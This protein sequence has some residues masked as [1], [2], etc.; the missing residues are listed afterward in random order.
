MYTCGFT[1]SSA[2]LRASVPL[3]ERR[4]LLASFCGVGGMVFG[5]DGRVFGD[6]EWRV[7]RE[8]CCCCGGKRVETEVTA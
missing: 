1:L 7:E 6:G 3:A 2:M 4:L 5:V 8:V